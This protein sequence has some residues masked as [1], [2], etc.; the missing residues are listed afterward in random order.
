M[1]IGM[2]ML[3]GP[4][5]VRTGDEPL[6]GALMA[7]QG[8][9]PAEA[10]RIASE[11]LK[12]QPRHQ[13]AL[14]V[15]GC[16]LLMQ[17]R[18]KDAIVP[19]EE[20]GRGRH[21]PEIDTQLAIALRQAGRTKDALVKLKRATKRRPPFAPAFHELGYALFSLRRYDEAVDVLERGI[22]VAPMMPELSIQL[23]F[24]LLR[25]RSREAAKAAFARALRVSPSAHQALFGMAIAHFDDAQYTAAAENYRQ[26]LRVQPDDSHGWLNLGHCLLALHQ[27]EAG[28]ECFRSAARGDPARQGNALRSLVKASKGRFWMKQSDA[29]RFFQTKLASASARESACG[30]CRSLLPAHRPGR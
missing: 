19:L 1:I 22:E 23:G 14:H 6:H 16:A 17:G 2:D 9:R 8:Q 3:K 25:R 20:A 24:V 4:G 7:L 30:K 28:Y 27:L 21:D 12:A 29:A 15:L 18:A 5:E 11:F 13:R 10:E 26:Y